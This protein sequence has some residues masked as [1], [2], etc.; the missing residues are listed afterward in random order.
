MNKCTSFRGSAT[1]YCF[2]KGMASVLGALTI[3]ASAQAQ[4][5][6]VPNAYEGT[7]AGS[8]SSVL[9][10]NIRLQ[11]IYA[12]SSLPSGPIAISEIRLRPSATYG[13]AFT[14]TIA[15]IEIRLSTTTVDAAAINPTFAQNVGT[16]EMVVFSGA[17]SLSSTFAGPSGGPKAFDIIIPLSSSFVY[18]PSQGNLLVDFRN[19]SG[20]TVT[21]VDAGIP[22]G[23]SSS[24]AF[25]LGVESATATSASLGAE[26]LQLVYAPVATPPVITHQPESLSAT[27]GTVATFSVTADSAVAITFQWRH[28]GVDIPAATN[29]SLVLSNVQAADAG[30]YTVVVANQFGSTTSTGAVLTVT[31]PP[32][33]FITAQ[34]ASQTVPP[35]D[36]AAFSV[37]VLSV[38][39]ITYAW[40]KDGIALDGEM[41]PSLVI[42]NVQ[43]AQA[44]GYSVIVSNP[45]GS[46]TSAVAVLTVTNVS[47]IVV[48]PGYAQ[49]DAGAGSSTLLDNI[50]LQEVYSSALFPP[51]QILIT[52]LR[53]RPSAAGH[54]SSTVISDLQLNLST[55]TIQPGHLSATFGNN[56]G[57]DDTVVFHGSLSVTSAFTGPVNGPKDFDIVVRLTTP[58]PYDPSAGNLLVDVRNFSGSTVSAV[59]AGSP[60]DGLVSRAFALGAT[61]TVGGPAPGADVLQIGYSTAPIAPSITAQPQD[62]RVTEGQIA[63]L[64]VL[65]RGTPPLSYQ[66]YFNDTPISDANGSALVI[67]NIQPSAAGKY[68]VVVDNA[69]GSVTSRVATLTVDMSRTL[70][71]IA[72]PARQEGTRI[73]LLLDLDSDGDVGG[74]TFLL[75]Y[76]T[77]YLK[78][79]QLNWVPQL[80]GLFNSVN[81]SPTGQI[82]ATFAL[83]GTAVPTGHQ[84]VATL[85]F[86][87][88]SVPNDLNTPLQVQILDASDPSGDPITHGNLA[89]NASVSITKRL[90]AGDNNAN[91]RLD[92]GDASVIL[93]QLAGLEQTRAWDVTGNDLNGS[94]NLDS[95]DAIKVLRAAAGIDPQPGGEGGGGFSAA[96]ASGS[97]LPTES[98]LLSPTTTRAEAGS[99]VT[100]QVRLR[101]IRT[102]ISGAAFTLDFPTNALRLVN[103]QSHR[104]GPVVAANALLIWN[105][106]PSQNNFAT[107]NGRVSFAASSAN[108]WPMNDGVLAEL[109]FQVQAGASSHYQWPLTLR[110][111]EVTPNGYANRMLLTSGATF[112]GRDPLPGTI[113]TP[114]RNMAGLF[115]FT[116]V[117]D[118]GATYLI[119]SSTDLI[120]W[121]PLTSFLNATGS[122]H[123]EDPDSDT[124][125]RNFY[126]ARPESN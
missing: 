39:P 16:N 81:Y 84:S 7:D 57:P 28:D 111:A 76:D 89:N 38:Q 99:S 66:W 31:D 46:T 60:A 23:T 82:R 33:P 118:A 62:Q 44:G 112:I 1:R 50:R 114:R 85:D 70:A 88:R 72:P 77:N 11:E 100:F 43:P 93:G 86:L 22:P 126:R 45:Y 95:G 55:T 87:L 9:N 120:H 14:S 30:T 59:D 41:S 21:Y 48:H 94:S 20:S 29:A 79:A 67:S 115:E 13:S 102:A 24:R 15:S 27:L 12:A 80:E 109:T 10:D 3:A 19:Y 53:W 91:Q 8:G 96:S 103:S 25:A 121:T 49:Q 5:V 104:S 90:F 97:V 18:D 56:L 71:L 37:T 69:L 108:P 106:A 52:E 6:V 68:F 65:A 34:P 42:S 78:E 51:G 107:Q 64:S 92:V 98:L 26:V 110:A 122:F 74:M 117:G 2:V 124:R 73:T 17:L 58:F 101:N 35:G 47:T 75:N 113:A 54:P 4:T 123:F 125:A 40:A 119:E 61:S 36:V 63:T 116:V 32:P 105:V 83:S